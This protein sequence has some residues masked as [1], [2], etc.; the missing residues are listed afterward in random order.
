MYLD[1]SKN[2]KGELEYSLHKL[3]HQDV[4]LMQTMLKL[5]LDL[6]KNQVPIQD[7]CELMFRIAKIYSYLK[8]IESTKYAEYGK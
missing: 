2:E 1:K 8:I 7:S 3:T 4:M 5:G 6:Y